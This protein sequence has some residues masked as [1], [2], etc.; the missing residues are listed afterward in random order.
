MKAIAQAR[1][2]VGAQSSLLP[3]LH[4]S[5][6]DFR[7]YLRISTDDFEELVSSVRYVECQDT[8]MRSALT[9][10]EQLTITLRFLATGESFHSL[11]YQYCIGTSTV[12]N[13]VKR[14]H[15]AAIYQCTVGDN[16]R[17][18][19]LSLALPPLHRCCRWKTCDDQVPPKGRVFIFNYKRYHSM[20]P[21]ALVDADKMAIF[22]DAGVNGR[23]NDSVTFRGTELFQKLESGECNIPEPVPLPGQND[24]TDFVVVA[25]A[26]SPMKDYMLRPC[27]QRELQSKANPVYNYSLVNMDLE[28]EFVD[29]ILYLRNILTV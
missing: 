7:G 27:A 18:I 2:Q 20:V 19:P 25:D 10:E 29:S 22:V 16:C 5:D 28:K 8:L 17:Q 6:E 12:H 15:E 26:A 24:P 23:C 21:M 11:H 9:V 13:K 14:L 1:P 4:V 3:I